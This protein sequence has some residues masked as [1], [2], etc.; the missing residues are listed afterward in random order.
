MLV[1]VERFPVIPSLFDEMVNFDRDFETMF[2]M[3][4]G[5]ARPVAQYPAIDVAEYENEFV[6]VAEMPGVS[7]E[8]VR[9]SVEDNVLTISGQRNSVQIPEKSSWVRN[10]IETGEFMRT[11][12]LPHGAKVDAISAE[13]SNGV[14]RITL[15]KA[16][17]V[18]PR[19][20]AIR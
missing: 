15:P 3:F 18:R 8:D 11:I 13:L 4:P 14:L 7:K 2:D 19:E 5:S 20:I 6:V 16:E 1:R 12:S 10:E 9:L 17:E